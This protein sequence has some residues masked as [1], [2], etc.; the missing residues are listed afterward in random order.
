MEEAA[1]YLRLAI[2]ELNKLNPVAESAAPTDQTPAGR[3]YQA[4]SLAQDALSW[5][6]PIA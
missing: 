5:T 3:A 2:K 4:R 6:R 1:K